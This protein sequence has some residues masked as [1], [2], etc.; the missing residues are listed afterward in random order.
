MWELNHKEGWL[1]KNW[2]F[3]TVVLENTLE[4]PLDSK[5][6]KPVNPKGN[7]LW[8]FIGRTG[9]EVK[10]QYFGHLMQRADSLEKT[11]WWESLKIGG[12][13][14]NRMRCSDDITDSTDMSL[15]KFQEM[16][17]DR[18]AWHARVHG[19]TKSHTWLIDW[20]DINSSREVLNLRT[21]K[22]GRELL[23]GCLWSLSWLWQCFTVCVHYP[24]L[25]SY[26]F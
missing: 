18:E 13:G 10:L 3:Q 22:D 1:P 20:I 8:I 2:C 19:V 6:T 5:E 26:I 15:S 11:L 4:S 23:E 16:V 14:D 9:A 12:N 17:L 24:M 25:S 7:Q 21:T